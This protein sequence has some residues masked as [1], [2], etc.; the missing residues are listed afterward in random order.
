MSQVLYEERSR[1]PLARTAELT[2]D[3]LRRGGRTTPLD[4]LNL[5]A[6]AE[7]YLR[8][9]WLGG[10]G[11][12]RPLQSLVQGPGVVPVTRVTGTTTPLKVRRSADFAR[13]L[14]ELA[15]RRCGGPDQVAALAARAQAEGVPLWIARRYAPGPAGP[16]AVAVD[17]RLVRVD[18][19]GPGAPA[20]RLRAP[21]GFRGDSTVPGSGLVMTVGD[22]GARLILQ[23]KFR[24]SKSSVEIR[25]PDRRWTLRR[26][27][28][29]SSGLLRDGRR[30]ALLT[31]PGR[32]PAPQPGS[33]LL[34]LADVRHESPDPL[35]AVMAHAV[36]VSFGLGD[37]TGLARFRA[38]NS[39][40]NTDDDTWDHPWFSNLGSGSD[41]N[42]PGGGDGWG[43]DG[44][45]G[46]DG[47]GGGGGGGGGDGGGGGGGD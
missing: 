11:A 18:V 14:G 17:R 31:R 44:G 24:K 36:A 23:K 26:E 12:E 1:N 10:G 35:D 42:E 22:T 30:V 19:W 40:R 21:Y 25:L 16:V 9:H 2:E 34:P 41:D 38:V 29:E 7:A 43:S 27:T 37:T 32:R 39:R 8:G 20:V 5:G 6:M 13:A 47:G 28:T 15:V 4:E 33:V 46:G 45:D 3:R